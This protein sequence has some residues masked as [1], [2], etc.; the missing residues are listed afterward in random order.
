MTSYLV[1][2]APVNVG[3]VV[4]TVKV[5][6]AVVSYRVIIVV[7][8]PIPKHNI[9]TVYVCPFVSPVTL[10]EVVAVALCI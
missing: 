7:P 5:N 6:V 2:D 9:S 3:A 1:V 10:V 8:V 4:S